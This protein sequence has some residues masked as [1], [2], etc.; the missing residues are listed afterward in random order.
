MHRA[1]RPNQNPGLPTSEP[2]RNLGDKFHHVPRHLD[3]HT[4]RDGNSTPNGN[5][6]QWNTGI[7]NTRGPSR[8]G[9]AERSRVTTEKTA[10][11]KKKKKTGRWPFTDDPLSTLLK[12]SVKKGVSPGSWISQWSIC[13][14]TRDHLV[15]GGHGDAISNPQGD[16]TTGHTLP[17]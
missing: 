14:G 9:D 5:Q 11:K 6:K 13:G 12:T 8:H 2:R 17:A 16:C 1:I 10:P 3:T 4:G 7:R 15:T